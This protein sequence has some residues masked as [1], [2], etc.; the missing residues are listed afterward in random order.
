[1]AGLS[2]ARFSEM[3]RGVG[4][5]GRGMLRVPFG[6]E[7]NPDDG[8]LMHVNSWFCDWGSLW[9]GGARDYENVVRMVDSKGGLCIVN[10][11]GGAYGWLN[12]EDFPDN[13]YEDEGNYFV[14][15]MQRLFERY[16]A[17]LGIEIGEMNNSELWDALLCNLAP[18]SRNVFAFGT[19]D[20]HSA[21]SVG[22]EC[23]WAAMPENSAENLRE[24]LRSGAFFA[25]MQ[26]SNDLEILALLEA[27][28]AVIE[29][30]EEGWRWWEADADVP[31]P[32]VTGITVK[33]N[34]ITL[35]I[36]NYKTVQ[37]ISDG[38][39]IAEGAALDLAA[40]RDVLGSY[41]RAQIRGDGG[42]LYTQPFLLSYEGMPAGRPV[43][44]RFV[45]WGRGLG[46]LRWGMYPPS[47]LIDKLEARIY[48]AY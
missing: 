6:I 47:Y 7:Q 4:R 41:V 40:H 27:E 48:K 17:L 2:E 5:E 42:I 9:P 28:G 1:V 36:E 30:D 23:V 39:I 29:E 31:A 21:E 10:H 11:P 8:K 25:A 12:G 14:H 19:D 3:A 43:P 38:K 35:E 33:N 34:T 22:W 24:C 26:W 13:L 18:S 15:K 44:K 46:W 16:P 32:M 45:D 37:W 20:S